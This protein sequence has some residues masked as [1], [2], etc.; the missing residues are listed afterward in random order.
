[1]NFIFYSLNWILMIIIPIGMGII[2]SRRR[3]ASW[4]FFAIGSVTFILS[5][6][7]HIP[8]NWFFFSWLTKEL[9]GISQTLELIIIAFLAGLSAGVFEESARYLSFRFWAKDARTWGRGLMLGAGHGGAESIILGI[10][11]GLNIIFL[12]LFNE[13]WFSAYLPL[14]QIPLLEESIAVMLDEP[15]FGAFLGAVE[16]LSVL[17][18]HLA[19]SIIVMQVFTRGRLRWLILAIIWHTVIDAV[20]VLSI[21][22]ISA[23]LVEGIIAGFALICLVIIF[24]LRTPEPESPPIEP[25]VLPPLILKEFD[26]TTRKLEDSRYE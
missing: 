9:F 19:L 23:Y 2:I 16:R 15:W 25:Y 3:K 1:M 22:Y 13:G 17:I 14:E 20:A 6:V 11:V 12:W 8:F 18:V 10:I 5:Q 26:I 4:R 21:R 7:A 24:L